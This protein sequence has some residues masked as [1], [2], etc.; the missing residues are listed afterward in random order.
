MLATINLQPVEF[1]EGETILEVARR[2]GTF[3]PT[4]CEFA[5]LNHRPGTCRM[6]LV[7]V[8]RADG[9]SRVVTACET[10][11]VEGDAVDTYSHK[12]RRMQKLQAELLFSDHCETCSGCARHGACELQ[13][14]A[15]VVGLDVT[16]LSGRLATRPVETDASANGLVFTPDKC[17]RCL[18][19]IEACRQV[20]GIG[21]IK[22]DH[23]GTNAAVSFGGPWGVRDLHPVR[24]VRARMPD[25]RPGRQGSDR[26][27]A[28]LVRRSRSHDRRAVRARRARDDR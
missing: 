13:K 16:R 10:R 7:E 4:L 19:C 28:R 12:V 27:R 25:R 5:A 11:L 24:P 8:T 6:C 23:T 17:I 2:T 18:R 21:V 26:L 15:R 20:Q 3:I 1:T 22:L 14:V 9:T